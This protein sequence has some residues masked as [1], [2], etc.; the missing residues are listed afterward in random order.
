MNDF[1]PRGATVV[2]A[3]SRIFHRANEMPAEASA[4]SPREQQRRLFSH[5]AKSLSQTRG[6][7]GSPSGAGKQLR[8]GFFSGQVG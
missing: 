8:T 1:V 4:K 5:K 3:C 7:S 2:L 6:Q